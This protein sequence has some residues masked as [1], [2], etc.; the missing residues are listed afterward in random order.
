MC[1][2]D[3]I[4]EPARNCKQVVCGFAPNEPLHKVKPL[5][6]LYC[7]H[8]LGNILFVAYNSGQTQNVAVG[9]RQDAHTCA[10]PIRLL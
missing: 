6:K 7:C 3:A 2:M 1:K 5:A 8:N 4:S 10:Y 9:D